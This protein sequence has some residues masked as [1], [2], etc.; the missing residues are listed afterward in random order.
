MT[1]KAAS[2][3][4]AQSMGFHVINHA[5]FLEGSTEKNAAQICRYLSG[6]ECGIHIW[7]GETTC[8]LPPNPGRGGRNQQFAAVAANELRATDD[9]VLLAAGTDGTD[10]PTPD[11]GGIVDGTSFSRGEALG[12]EIQ[13]YIRTADAGN[14]LELTGDLI[15]TGPTGTNVMDLV[16]ASKAD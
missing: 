10:G 3:S 5:E 12:L 13:Q 4:R 15:T 1:Q 14:Y 9:V 7:G 16:I 8:M 11:A 2:A 6:A